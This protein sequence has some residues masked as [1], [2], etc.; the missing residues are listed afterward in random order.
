MDTGDGARDFVDTQDFMVSDIATQPSAITNY[1]T[2]AITEK[3]L[4]CLIGLLVT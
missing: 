1:H 3:L 2:V 4:K